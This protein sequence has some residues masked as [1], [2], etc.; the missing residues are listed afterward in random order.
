MNP[1]IS[2][3]L[4]IFGHVEDQFEVDINSTM[5][6][7]AQLPSRSRFVPI[8]ACALPH[9]HAISTGTISESKV[10]CSCHSMS[11]FLFFICQFTYFWLTDRLRHM[12]TDRYDVTILLVLS[13]C[14]R[15]AF[16]KSAHRIRYPFNIIIILFSH[17]QS[18]GALD[19]SLNQL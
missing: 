12:L 18:G 13:P 1:N 6:I 11:F 17:L 8:K 5:K 19:F 14:A 7:Y 10:L 9:Q 4:S 2:T 16:V 15:P 3:K